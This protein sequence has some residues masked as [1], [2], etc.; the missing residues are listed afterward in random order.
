MAD[1]GAASAQQVFIEAALAFVNAHGNAAVQHGIG[2]GIIRS[3]LVKCVTALVNDAEHRACHVVSLVVGGDAD[4]VVRA[5]AGGEGVLGGAKTAMIHVNAH[6]LH[7][8]Q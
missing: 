2:K 7:E 3:Q 4:V 1:K 8:K 5:K 6:C